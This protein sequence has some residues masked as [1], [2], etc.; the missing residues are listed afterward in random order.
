MKL[1]RIRNHKYLKM[2]MP[3][4]LVLLLWPG[5]SHADI[6]I[7]GKVEI[8]SIQILPAETTAGKHPEITG[9]I[10]AISAKVPGEPM[11]VNVVATLVRPDNS[12]KSWTWKK[13]MIRDGE[14]RGFSL[15]KEYDVKMEGVYKVNFGVY[16]KDMRPLH[17]LSKSFAVVDS[18]RP[19]VS[20]T[21]P[22]LATGGTGTSFRKSFR[23]PDYHRIAAGVTLNAVNTARGATLLYWPFK[24][25]GLQASYSMG[26]FTT[27]EA[28]LLARHPLSAGFTPYLGLGYASVSAERTVDVIGIKTT[29]KDS[30][31]SGVI[32]AEIP[33][34][35]RV[36]GH[37]EISV[38]DI[39]L[40]KEVTNGGLTGLAR[41][42]YSPF[43]AGVSIVY[44]VF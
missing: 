35:R 28:R 40:K 2:T 11:E 42:K 15:P 34:T 7:A 30:G 38:A 23:R 31:V 6:A 20:T 12:V 21:S 3:A 44:F 32:G 10:K 37:V 1:L 25:L 19:R 29:F 22:Q 39:D 14:A 4:A 17:N 16:S 41:V 5:A 36:S 33:L 43:S 18:S 8:E 27:A 9:T 26:A 24:H 13:I